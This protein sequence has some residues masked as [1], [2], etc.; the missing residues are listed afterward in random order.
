MPC[1]TLFGP[2]GKPFGIA[3]SR[4]PLTPEKCDVCKAAPHTRLCDG[5]ACGPNK[6][7][8]TCDRKLC[9]S[10]ATRIGPDRDL[11]PDCV[12]AATRE[13]ESR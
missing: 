9:A 4:G 12:K 6:P 3:C 10:C 5:H 7:T 13:K 8:K 1:E 11:C 2:D